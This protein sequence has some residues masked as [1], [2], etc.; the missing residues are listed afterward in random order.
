MRRRKSARLQRR[1]RECVLSLTLGDR[2]KGV[3]TI[4]GTM[5]KQTLLSL[6][7]NVECPRTRKRGKFNQRDERKVKNAVFCCHGQL[8]R[9]TRTT[10]RTSLIS[11]VCSLF[12]E[13]I[14]VESV[15][16]V[17]S[18]QG[19]AITIFAQVVYP[20]SSDSPHVQ[21]SFKASL[22]RRCSSHTVRFLLIRVRFV[23]KDA[24]CQERK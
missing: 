9:F 13:R 21:R 16:R 15:T 22:S 8:Q 3:A 7:R 20:A 12:D 17:E 19:H 14:R 10:S 18:C 23:C 6:A 2:Y 24:R 5:H 11:S 1:W 4:D